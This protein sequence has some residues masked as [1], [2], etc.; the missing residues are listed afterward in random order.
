[1]WLPKDE[2]KLLV[3]YYQELQESSVGVRSRFY[4]SD[5]E[6][7]L[8]GTNARNRAR[9]ASEKLQRRNLIGFLQDQ[10]DAITVGLSLEGYDLDR[11]YNSFWIR[12]GLRFKEYKDHWI[13]L[14]VGF[15]GGVIGG[16]LVNW[17]S[18]AIK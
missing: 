16:L 2:R 15:L 7:V 1:M 14:I 10:G 3:Y 18:K 9:I 4:P 5:L 17:L 11:K 13:W 12:S 8:Q 6:R